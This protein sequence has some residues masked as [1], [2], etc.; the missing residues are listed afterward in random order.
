MDIPERYRHALIIVAKNCDGCMNCLRECP[1]QALR[2]R[3]NTPEVREE[4]CVDCGACIATCPRKAL[5]PEVDTIKEAQQFEYRVAVPSPVLYSQFGLD[6]SLEEIQLGLNRVGFH[7][8]YDVFEAC[9]MQ[10][11]AVQLHL[12]QGGDKVKKPLISSMCPAVVRLIQVKYPTLVDHVIPFE[13]PRELSAR[14]AKIKVSQKHGVEMGKV[15]AFYL[16]PCPAKSVS[17][18]QPA[19]KERSFLDGVIAISDIYAPLREAISQLDGEEIESFP[20]DRIVFGSGWERTG[21]VSLSMNIEK[22]IAV[23]GLHHVMRMLDHIEEG[24]LDGVDFIEANTCI[25][26]CMGGPLCVENLYLARSKI[27]MLEGNAPP[28]REPDPEWVRQLYDGG[29]FFMQKKLEPRKRDRLSIK[30]SIRLMSDRDELASRLP[31]LDCCACGSPTCLTFAED[32]L[33]DGVM[34]NACP[35]YK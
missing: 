6:R 19:E 3:N 18:L 30:E 13:P 24:K 22:W 17:V 11:R 31:G 29:Y 33:T 27:L 23:S 1:T 8:I 20:G 15:G 2:I 25:E 5:L 4:L 14:E 35:H 9:K 16:S 10:A 21:L 32:M 34:P 12:E 7:Y 26:G 28:S